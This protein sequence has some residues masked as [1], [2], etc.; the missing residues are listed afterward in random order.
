MLQVV[1]LLNEMRIGTESA[2]NTYK[3]HN[4][5]SQMWFFVGSLD[6]INDLIPVAIKLTSPEA[7]LEALYTKL[8]T[9]KNEGY[10]DWQRG[11][12]QVVKYLIEWVEN[13]A[14]QNG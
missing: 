4:N 3:E 6:V 13:R 7:F 8:F 10:G 9:C 2:A 11:R 1:K 12:V 5:V 14:I